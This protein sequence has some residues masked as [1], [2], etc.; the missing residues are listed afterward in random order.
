MFCNRAAHR[1]GQLEPDAA[2]VEHFHHCLHRRLIG[3]AFSRDAGEM[4]EHDVV[5]QR[6]QLVGVFG[7]VGAVRIELDVPAVLVDLGGDA[8]RE[9]RH[10]LAALV[11]HHPHAVHAKPGEA[12]QFGRLDVV[13]H[14]RDAAES[15]GM[16]RQH[17]GQHGSVAAVA[18]GA[19]D[20][21][22]G[23]PQ[24]LLQ[25]EEHLRRRVLGPIGT[26]GRIRG[27]RHE[28]VDVGVAGAGRCDEFRLVHIG[29]GGGGELL[30]SGC[31]VGRLRAG[32]YPTKLEGRK[33]GG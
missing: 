28:Q 9:V 14:Q 24:L 32:T 17:V 20:D 1:P 13:L 6:Q 30:H 4:V 29:V 25:L 12:R 27:S 21:G 26:V 22:G 10:V 8:R 7:D 2:G 16:L 18:A 3:A 15:L 23:E 31:S 11:A 33:Q 5:L 19:D